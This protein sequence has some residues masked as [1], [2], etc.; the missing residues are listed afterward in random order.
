M[1]RSR[2]PLYVGTNHFVVALD[3]AT[4]EEL[5]RTKLR[6]SGHG[7]PVAI[8]IQRDHLFVGCFGQAYCL[9]R[10]DG[11]ILWHNNLP[12][13]G[14]HAVVLAM[15]GAAGCGPGALLVADH[16][17]REAARAAAAAGATA[18]I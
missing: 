12:G 17:R 14:Y 11:Q 4:G 6:G 2:T 3:P 13:T 9:D 8:L 5:W 1:P 16:A 7:H 10:R 18:A 15:E